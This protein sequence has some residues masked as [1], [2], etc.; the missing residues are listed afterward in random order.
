[1]IG[2]KGSHYRLRL[3]S[4]VQ[5]GVLAPTDALID[6]PLT[7]DEEEWLSMAPTKLLAEYLADDEDAPA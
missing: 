5:Q 7:G 4:L 3:L 6:P 1:M 2:P